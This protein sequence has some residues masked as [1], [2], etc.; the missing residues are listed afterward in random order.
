MHS[1]KEKP[2][3]RTLQ[4]RLGL[5]AL[6]AGALLALAAH[7][8]VHA[9]DMGAMH[10]PSTP[11]PA[12]TAEEA[13]FLHGNDAVMAKMMEDMAIK[14]TGNVDKDFVDTMVPHHQGA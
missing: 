4:S 7:L 9:H 1:Y 13:P 6:G 8:P 14:P 5:A 2:M 3:A 12:V 11:P 10:A